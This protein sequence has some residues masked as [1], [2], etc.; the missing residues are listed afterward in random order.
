MP[1]IG[2]LS[3]VL[4]AEISRARRADYTVGF[5]LIDLDHFKNVNDQYGHAAGDQ[6]LV[7]A[8]RT[9]DE[10]TRRSDIACRYGGEEFLVILPEISLEDA[11]QRGEQLCRD[12]ENLEIEFEGQIIRLTVSIGVAIFPLHG[13]SIDQILLAVDAALYKAK[14]NGRNQIALSA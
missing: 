2:C 11:A 1:L 7:A 3:E 12:I 14:D 10:H 6:A 5:M 9:I 4:P 13:E 8:S